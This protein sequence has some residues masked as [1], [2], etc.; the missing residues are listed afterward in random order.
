MGR[1][2]SAVTVRW[3]VVSAL[4]VFGP[5]LS[6]AMQGFNLKIIASNGKA[7]G[8]LPVS[9]VSADGKSGDLGFTDAE[10]DID[11]AL[12]PSKNGKRFNVYKQACSRIVFAEEGSDE[13]KRCKSDSATL[14]NGCRSCEPL[15]AFIFGESAT[16][17]TLS[18]STGGVRIGAYGAVG[19]KSTTIGNADA[20]VLIIDGRFSS[21]NP[22]YDQP[23]QIDVKKTASGVG[24]GGGIW[25]AWTPRFGTKFGVFGELPRDVPTQNVRGTRAAGGLIFEQQGSS[26]LSSVALTLA[27]TITLGRGLV[28]SGGPALTR[29]NVDFT[30]TGSLRAGGQTVRTDNISTQ[31]K[32]TAVGFF[33]GI[34]YYPRNQWFG[35][36]AT[37]TQTTFKDVYPSTGGLGWPDKWK[38]KNFFVGASFRT[39]NLGQ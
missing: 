30:Q 5:A 29:W 12:D 16:I 36:L 10:G 34:E 6:A 11:L 15:G 18:T 17:G 27:P 33:G 7:A 32:G 14:S 39:G 8:K 38:D 26:T 24:I 37:Y 4:I 2:S 23:R 25:A 9:I 13:D 35:I 1:L 22:P 3:I 21:A 28:I 20:A 31:A 19:G